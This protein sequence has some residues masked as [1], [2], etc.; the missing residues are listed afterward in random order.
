MRSLL[1][2]LALLWALVPATAWARP[3]IVW[4]VVEGP[5]EHERPEARR[6]HDLGQGPLDQT[7]RLLAGQL[8][9]VEHRVEAMSLEKV[10]RDMRLGRP[11]CFA[12][13]FKTNERLKVA[14]FVELS[15]SPRML[16]VALAG[17]LPPGPELSLRELLAAGELRGLFGRQRSYGDELDRVLDEFNPRR[18]PMPP[19]AKLLPMLQQ[20]RMDF[21]LENA[22]GWL[23][24]TEGALDVR[25]VREGRQTPPVHVACGRGVRQDLVRQVDGAVRQL[26]RL[27]EWLQLKLLSYPPMARD[28][29]RANLQRYLRQRAE[30]PV[31]SD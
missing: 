10:W 23:Q 1:L 26:S 19:D 24:T 14:R 18:E 5:P 6:I 30:Q 12:D 3:V 15:P 11:V 9:E 21:L 13:A 4:A 17:R 27:D 22:N 25:L 20:G 31:V 28:E 8:P 29:Q 16:L 2:G 7:L